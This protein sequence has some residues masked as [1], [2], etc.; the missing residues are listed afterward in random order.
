MRTEKTAANIIINIALQ[1]TLA[2]SGLLVPRFFIGAYGSSVNGLVSSIGQFITYMSLVEAGI[3][4]AGTVLLY[5]PLAEGNR[6]EVSRV[7]ST[8]RRF[9]FRA[10]T[11]FVG[12]LGVLTVLYPYLVQNEIGDAGFIRRM[13]LVLAST[14]VFDY[15]FLGRNR[16]LLQ[17]DQK[18]YVIS[19]FQIIGTV[20]MT[21][22]SILMIRAGASAIAVKAAAAAIYI[23]RGVAVEAYV[24]T[25]YPDVSFRAAPLRQGLPQRGSVL[26]HQIAA[27]V[28]YNTDMVLLTICLPAGA[29][30]E[31][32][33]Y[34]TYSLAAYGVS[35]LLNAISS[36]S[37]PAFGQ[38]IATGQEDT[39]RKAYREFECG[40]MVIV[41]A[42]YVCMAV[43][44]SPFIRLYSGG[45]PDAEMYARPL[46][47]VLFTINGLLQSLRMPAGTL[48]NAA[49]HFRQTR[50]RAAAEAL[51]NLAVSLALVFRWGIYGVLA[52][53]VVSNLY[54]TI[55]MILYASRHILRDGAAAHFL[56]IGKYLLISLPIAAAGRMLVPPAGLTWIGWL[57]AAALLGTAALLALA[58]GAMLLDW[59]AATAIRK[60]I[61]GITRRR[62]GGDA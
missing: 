24:R 42:C 29:L 39:L 38:V 51:I 5:K 6:A 54:R 35:S 8:V 2:L 3:G 57:G 46:L 33:V 59:E 12:L 55:D 9:Y 13:I 31:V 25:R 50:W 56:R 19:L 17:A 15:F 26:F 45:F 36:G 1:I 37:T 20:L 58:A 16:V 53:T 28:V 41:F 34:S 48:I 23:L 52:G 21:A 22:V 10:G 47:P 7:V 27:L 40:G 61:R 4:A 60:R 49:G 14:T 62:G 43:L 11:M 30:R 44:L 18:G 32:S